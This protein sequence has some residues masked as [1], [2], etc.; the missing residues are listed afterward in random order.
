MQKQNSAK[1][2]HTN[3]SSPTNNHD[4]CG[5]ICQNVSAA[6]SEPGPCFYW[7]HQLMVMNDAAKKHNNECPCCPWFCG[8]EESWV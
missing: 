7:V 8:N 5:F 6:A 3:S 2:F 1:E 4:V